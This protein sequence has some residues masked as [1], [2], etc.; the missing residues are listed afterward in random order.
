[1]DTF[2]YIQNDIASQSIS[3]LQNNNNNNIN[4]YLLGPHGA[5]VLSA[6][7]RLNHLIPTITL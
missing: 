5:P 1:M 3:H 7:H 2:A 6:L 4:Q